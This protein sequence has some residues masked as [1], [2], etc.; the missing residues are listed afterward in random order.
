MSS[1]DDSIKPACTL[2]LDLD[3]K[4]AY[5]KTH[6]DERWKSFPSYLDDVIPS[7]LEIL[8]RHDL[9]I[10]VMVVGQDA[11][12]SRNQSA[13]H[14]IVDGGHELG[15]HSFSHESW[16][17]SVS[18]EQAVDDLHRAHA[19]I[20]T[21]SNAK[22]VGFRGPSYSLSPAII[23]WLV[24]N[25]YLYDASTFPTVLGPAARTYYF[26]RSSFSANQ[27]RERRRLFGSFSDGFRP[28]RP[29]RWCTEHGEIVELPVSTLPILRLPFHFSYLHYVSQFSSVLAMCYFRCALLLCRTTSTAPSILLHPLD[30]LGADDVD[31]LQ[32]FPGMK[33]KGAKKREFVSRA[34]ASV[35]RQYRVLTLHEHVRH[36][37]SQ[38]DHCLG[39]K[40]VAVEGRLG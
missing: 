21:L 11:S 35:V 33:L 9:T 22:L 26:M 25:D 8:R 18:A 27:R 34:L 37:R 12:L 5:L 2:S 29:Y 17:A 14:S 28:L 32:F 1:Q 38:S 40:S 3:D 7:F 13:L 36:L 19:A 10:T 30:F 31:D 23:R 20:S 16:L 15:N 4:W 6:G 39:T 24:D